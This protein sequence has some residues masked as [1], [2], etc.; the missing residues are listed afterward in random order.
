VPTLRLLRWLYMGRVTLATGIFIGALGTWSRAPAGTTL[1]ATLALV[2]SVVVTVASL[3]YTE[4]W[5]RRPGRTF[6][7]GQLFYDTLLVTAVVHITTV[8]SAPSDFAALY[9]LV[10]GASALLLPLPGGLVIG[11]FAI[12]CYLVDL[13]WL[14]SD[15]QP[16]APAAQQVAL[17]GVLA[18]VTAWLGHRVRRTGAILDEMELQLRQLRTDNAE[19]MEMIDTG[20]LTADA[21]GRLVACNKAAQQLL[22]LE[23]SEWR[24]RPVL[25]ELDRRA[26]GLGSVIA[27]TIQT[28]T[29]V[30]RH[31]LRMRTPDGDRFLGLRTTVLPREEGAWVTAVVQD[32]TEFKQVED[33][34]RRAER[35]QAV[36][37]LGA[38]LAHEIKNPLASIRSSVEQ[39]ASDRLG[40]AD[41][42]TLLRLVLSESDRLSRLLSDFMEF[43]R[44]ELR[45]W[46][47]IDVRDVVTQAL[48]L[49]AQHP[50]A[51]AGA[52]I[53]YAAPAEPVEVDGDEDLL[54]R[55][56]FN[57]LLNAMQHSGP[58]GVVRVSLERALDLD[59]PASVRLEGPVRITVQDSGPGIRDEDIPH[60]FDPF[61]TT[62]VNG[63][64]LGL[65][66]VHRAVEAHGGA[67]LVDGNPGAGARFTVYLPSETGR[68]R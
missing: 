23:T 21:A 34:V 61:F 16:T 3:W 13:F 2:L 29:P 12:L 63:N 40:R 33:L 8:G 6:L 43:S 24:G 50:D 53:D 42:D 5:G 56:V 41:R 25:E 26:P 38:S 55:A 37:E 44:L 19:I 7:Y 35:L 64:G 60:L 32:V 59:L 4:R 57:L 31:E 18:L 22:G 54:H 20:L 27:R 36:A 68:R 15:V 65:A 9:V 28:Q 49:V 48:G 46:R 11:A 1:V 10:I 45:R 66:M 67:I 39:L 62:R 14:Q 52:R 58:G 51:E 17:F 47:L 30:R